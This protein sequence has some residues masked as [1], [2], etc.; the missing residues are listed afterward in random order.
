MTRLSL[1]LVLAVAGSALAQDHAHPM[2]APYAGLEQRP[3][4]ALS[5]AQVADLEAGRGMGLALAAELNLYPGPT[6]V[7]EL[8][9]SLD[10]TQDQRARA[11]V[12]R[13]AMTRA[14]REA[15]SGVIEAEAALDRLFAER[16]ADPEALRLA[17]ATAGTRQAELRR[18]HL[19]AHLE[20]VPILTPEQIRR[21]AALRGY[22]SDR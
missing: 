15:G 12:V 5:P 13:A 21:Y 1:F 11:E 19:A 3:I 6:H 14:A 20:M 16:R 22:A 10:L 17:L 2:K 18:I 9:E 8:A 7:L 4:K